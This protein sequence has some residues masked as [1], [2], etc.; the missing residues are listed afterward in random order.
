MTNVAALQTVSI[1][2]SELGDVPLL[3]S[4][5]APA[6]PVPTYGTMRV[7]CAWCTPPRE[8]AHKRCAAAQDGKTTHGICPDCL[9]QFN[10]DYGLEPETKP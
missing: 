9:A 2:A 6:L 5:G 4:L 7:I 3:Y 8:F 1:P 10:H